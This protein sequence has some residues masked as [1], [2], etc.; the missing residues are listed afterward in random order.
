MNGE[1]PLQMNQF[2]EREI[3]SFQTVERSWFLG[4]YRRSGTYLPYIKG[5]M[6]E[7]G[8]PEQLA[9]LAFIE[10]GY[11]PRAL[12]PARALGLWQFIPSTGY[13]YGMTRDRWI[14]HRMDFERSTTAAIAYLRDLHAM[15]GDWNAALAAYNCGEGRVLRTINSQANQYM[16]DFWDLY[17]RLPQETARYVPRFHAVMAIMQDPLKYGFSDLP[18]PEPPIA[19]D[20]LIVDRQVK[21]ADIAE[22]TGIDADVL[23][24]LNAELRTGVTPQYPYRL[25]VP[26]GTLDSVAVAVNAVPTTSA[27]NL[28]DLVTH[29]VKRGETIASIAR[30][31]HTT[32]AAIR[33]ENGLRRN[34]RV[35]VG[36]VLRI[37]VRSRT[38][39]PSQV[40]SSSARTA[41][42][43]NS[44]SSEGS[45]SIYVVRSG[46]TL[47]SISQRYSLSVDELRRLN[48]LSRRSTIKPGQ[49]LVVS[50]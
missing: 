44:H 11:S 21:L 26:V 36:Q 3:R 25:R 9:W 37:P 46:D 27:P 50:R 17:V 28:P 42:N 1:I 48:G 14:D 49:R 35:R 20:T 32:V 18:Q 15:F 43:S 4:A 8:L 29:R 19:F 2:V 40:A 6:R 13:R 22:R 41:R 39:T 24:R 38:S 23:T 16:D 7:A 12:S 31:H 30:K 33:Q 47:W 34:S 10:S 5:R 45:P